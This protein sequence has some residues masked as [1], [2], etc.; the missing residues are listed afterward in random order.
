[1]EDEE[2]LRRGEYEKRVME[3]GE[4]WALGKVVR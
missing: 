1:M 4:R 2:R 3:F